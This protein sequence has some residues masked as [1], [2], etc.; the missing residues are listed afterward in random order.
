MAD[1]THDL[2]WGVQAIADEIGRSYRQTIHLLV[3]KKIP[4]QKVGAIW[5]GRRSKIR[6]HL[7]GETSEK[8]GGR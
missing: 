4:G 2:I 6:A 3:T 8:G 1:D 7:S 5:I